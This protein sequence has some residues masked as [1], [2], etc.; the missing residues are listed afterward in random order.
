[1]ASYQELNNYFYNQFQ[2]DLPRATISRWVTKGYVKGIKEKNIWNYDFDSFKQY[3]H[4]NEYQTKARSTKEKPKDYIGKTIGKLKVIGIVPKEEY[5]QQYNGTLM[6]CD[7]LNCGKKH[8]QVRFSYLTT[9]GN[10]HQETCGCGRKQR[11]FLASSRPG[12]R[13]EFIN[14]YKDNFEWFLFLHKLLVDSATDRYYINCPIEEYE[15]A[16]QQLEIDKQFLMVYNFWKAHKK[17]STYYDWAKP[18]LDHI[19]PKSK[20][21]G[22]NF[23]NLQVLTVFENLAKRDMT[24]EEWTEFKE[25][26][27]TTSDYFIENIMSERRENIV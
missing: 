21:G 12:M 15:E 26:T 22:N 19:I 17:E 14:Q 25:K 3:I 5:D 6:Y 10:Y 11:A 16:I 1:M 27:H 4:S 24:Q 8:I 2:R 20:G 9:N 23:A 13:E 7:C 18:S